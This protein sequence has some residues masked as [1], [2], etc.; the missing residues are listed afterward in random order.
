MGG[1][2]VGRGAML[3]SST[4]GPKNHRFPN[5]STSIGN[6]NGHPILL[7]NKTSDIECA[8]LDHPNIDHELIIMA[9][10]RHNSTLKWILF[11]LWVAANVILWTP[12]AYFHFLGVLLFLNLETM[13]FYTAI[14]VAPFIYLFCDVLHCLLTCITKWL[15][16]GCYKTGKYSFYGTMHYKWVMMMAVQYPLSNFLESL[17]GTIFANIYY[18]AMGASVGTNACILANGILEADLISI[19]D[20][21]SIGRDHIF[22]AHTIE[23]MLIK[24]EPVRHLRGSTVRNRSFVLPGCTME[25]HS[26]LLENSYTLKGETIPAG[27]RWSGTPAVPVAD[28]MDNIGCEC[29]M[30]CNIDTIKDMQSKKVD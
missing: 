13:P 22:T 26:T 6:Q 28:G 11:N 27:E 9:R 10:Y 29:D 19:G 1:V 24:M 23:N 18:R 12:M 25:R 21:V 16:V 17:Q 4:L 15:V 20:E 14:L 5:F 30:C 3:G 7:R 2:V 8:S